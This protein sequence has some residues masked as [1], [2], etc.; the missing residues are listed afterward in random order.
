V[1]ACVPDLDHYKGSFGGRAFP[2]WRDGGARESNVR[3]GLLAALEQRYGSAVGP[4]DVLAYI[5]AAA[6]HPAFA[7]R[8]TADLSTPGLRIPFTADEGTFRRAVDLGRRVVWLQT[9]GERMAD[10]AAGRPLQPPR[11]PEERRPRIPQDGAIP[12]EPGRMPDSID[13]D[14]TRRRLLIGAGF[15]DN[16]PSEVWRYE[17]SGKQVLRHWF[18][19]RKANRERPIIGERRRPSPL[20]DIQPDHWLPEY[21]AELI[22]VLNVL[23]MLVELE[24]E[25]ARLL[26]EI[27]AGS[28]ITAE[29]LRKAGA[30]DEV[31]NPT[32]PKSRDKKLLGAELTPPLAPVPSSPS[33]SPPLA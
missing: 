11:L 23:G 21:T 18:S 12:V 7:K 16:V 3:A 4:E 29:E 20:G 1:T 5:V 15:V 33:S 14:A 6:A 25:Q 17:V 32:R 2:L 10:P 13:Y 22:N 30:F 26:D 9:F 19:Y 31:A 27:C 28:A 24:P 8:F